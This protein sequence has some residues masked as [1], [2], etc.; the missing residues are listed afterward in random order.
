VIRSCIRK[1]MI[2]AALAAIAV[3]VLAGTAALAADDGT[4]LVGAN[5]DR[6]PQHARALVIRYN[7][8]PYVGPPGQLPDD[9][10]PKQIV[11]AAIVEKS[12]VGDTA[13]GGLHLGGGVGLIGQAT[14]QMRVETSL[15]NLA[16]ELR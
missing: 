2:G 10:P 3:A 14:P 13:V 16:S 5:A 9:P 12:T 8:A 7:N 4:V 1:A 6:G 15:K 11:P